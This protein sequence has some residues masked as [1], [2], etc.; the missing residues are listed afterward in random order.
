MR[1]AHVGANIKPG[2]STLCA[3]RPPSYPRSPIPS[4]AESLALA[5]FGH[6]RAKNAPSKNVHMQM[7][8]FLKPRLTRV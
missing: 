7:R 2:R 5:G 6:Q 8:H 1:A 3:A 4:C